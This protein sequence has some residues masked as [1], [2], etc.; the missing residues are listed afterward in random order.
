MAMVIPREM[1][2]TNVRVVPKIKPA[3]NLRP[4]F[5]FLE[6]INEKR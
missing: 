3:F 1:D 4:I 6:K 2:K 5:K